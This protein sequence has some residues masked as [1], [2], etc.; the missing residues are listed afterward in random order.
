MSQSTEAKYPE[1]DNAAERQVLRSAGN[2]R[3]VI[4]S[5][6]FVA[7]TLNYMDRQII[8]F[9]QPLLAQEF[10][11]NQIDYANI[12]T[13]F[14]AAYALGMLVM[15][16]F[17]DRMGLRVG[18][19]IAVGVWSLFAA[20]H[21][22]GN[23]LPHEGQASVL[24][25]SM[26]ATTL[27]VAF[28][29]AMRFGMGVAEGGNFPAAIKT[30]SEWFPNRERSLATGL[31]NS[32][33]NVGALLTPLFVPWLAD[34]WGW[35]VAFYATG[36]IGLCWMFAWLPIY[37]AP[38]R[39]SWLSQSELSLIQSDSEKIAV[40]RISW[41]E[42]LRYPTTWAFSI[43]FV[44]VAPVWWFLLFWIPPFLHDQHNVAVTAGD[45]GPP[46]LLIYT[47][48]CVGSVVGGWLPSW[49]MRFGFGLWGTRR[50]TMFICA[51]A[52]APIVFAAGGTSL[53]TAASLI[54]LAAGAH[55]GFSANLFSIVSDNMPRAVVGSVVGIGGMAGAVASMF[56]AKAV[57]QIL[58]VTHNDYFL[59]FALAPVMYF[60]TVGVLLL[61][62]QSH[63]T[64]GEHP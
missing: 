40:P 8:G 36:A 47:A 43:G 2:F 12:V 52:V 27:S 18:Y 41:L 53:W 62:R 55:Q 23:M 56:A 11:W 3:W 60:I 29:C 58:Y 13:A 44:L 28:F 26:S 16:W 33:S 21:G 24:G 39:H 30:V 7:T 31:F 1:A 35:H 64:S 54:A 42:L 22:L 48:A 17:V 19:A 32:G 15:G 49:F 20:A 37:R 34:R 50:L 4:C 57:G 46:V 45:M 10:H 63:A 14:Q 51:L 61:L 25:I 9:L 59:P 38:E 5:L 6:L